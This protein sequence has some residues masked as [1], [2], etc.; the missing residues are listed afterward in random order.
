MDY[1]SNAQEL[2][3][4]CVVDLYVIDELAEK[5]D[6]KDS[7]TPYDIIN[8]ARLVESFVLCNEVVIRDQEVVIPEPEFFDFDYAFTEQWIKKFSDNHVIKYGLG[9]ASS[10]LSNDFINFD[11][12]SSRIAKELDDWLEHTFLMSNVLE[13]HEKYTSGDFDFVRLHEEEIAT[14]IWEN[15]TSF[16]GVPFFSNDLKRS[17]HLAKKTTNLSLDL[18]QKIESYYD[19]YFK[20]I[21]KYL[22]PTYVKIPF[23]LGL[24]L[25]ECSSLADIPS[26]TMYIRDR[27]AEFNMEVTELEYQLRTTKTIF[28]QVKIL[29]TIKEGYENI[30]NKY[31]SNKKRLLSRVF[32][33]VQSLDLK[34][35]TSTLIKDVRTLQVEENGLLL[36]PGYYD[37][38]KAVEEVEQ[39]LPQLKRLFGKQLNDSFFNDL[40]KYQM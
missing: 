28:E 10:V 5:I 6:Y 36:I 34:E 23:L 3:N 19:S 35:M 12:R 1:F 4:A 14:N 22:G 31:S 33:I 8:L 16:Y 15:M 2:S 20:K 30:A 39:A 24:V 27:F 26:A 7:I 25:N 11:K 40:L 9:C 32:D 21:S 17:A 38:W 37:I 29:K 13:E 18:Y